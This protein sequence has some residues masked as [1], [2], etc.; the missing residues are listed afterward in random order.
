[1]SSMGGITIRARP[2]QFPDL[3]PAGPARRQNHGP[4]Y[5]FVD[6][7]ARDQLP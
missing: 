1:M 2:P 4:H 5:G 3:S 6:A 7:I